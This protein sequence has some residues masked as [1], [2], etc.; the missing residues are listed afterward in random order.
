MHTGIQK[1]ILLLI[2]LLTPK[3]ARQRVKSEA[4]NNSDMIT[5]ILKREIVSNKAILGTLILNNKEIAK[6]LENPWL[7]NAEKI[8]CIPVGIYECVADN[9]GRFQWWKVLNVPDRGSIE[10]HE[11]NREKDTRGCIL[12]GKDW[13][14]YKGELA[15]MSSVK[16]L[17][18]I[19]PTLGQRF[20]LKITEN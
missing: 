10:I 5:V 9:T 19:R 13:G 20:Q 6:T 3:R 14:F 12:I 4:K 1:V 11:G 17:K 7:N 18:K 16:T 2:S 15:V 8:S